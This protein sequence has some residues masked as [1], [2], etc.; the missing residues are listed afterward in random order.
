MARHRQRRKAKDA[1]GTGPS[2]EGSQSC[3]SSWIAHILWMAL[4]VATIGALIWNQYTL[5]F[6]S[7]TDEQIHFY[8]A[9]R[10]VEGAVLYR[11]ID[12]ARPPLVLLPLTWLLRLGVEPLLAGRALVLGTQLATAGLQLWGGRLLAS[13]R[14]GV[15]AALLFLTSPEVFSRIH[16]TGIHLVAL[17]T[18]AC[19][20]SFLRAQ[21]LL[22]GL[23]FGLTLA[24]D[25][26]GIV[27]CSVVALLTLFRRSRDIIPFTMGASLIA[28]IVF[29]GVWAM[30]GR[31]L[32]N[33][34]VDVHLHHFRLG[35]GFGAEF[36][37]K[38]R[39][40]L[41][42]HGYL[43]V[44][45]AL[46]FALLRTKREATKIEVPK[47]PSLSVVRVLL[48]VVGAHVAV[49][50]AMAESVFLYMVVIFPLLTLL[51]AIGY[52][53]ALAWW[54]QRHQ[55]P[56]AQARRASELMVAGAVVLVVLTAA[57]WGMSF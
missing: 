33:S 36:W 52:D 14:A 38:L 41:Y 24:A 34:L 42:E 32:W 8:I 15:I 44:G 2:K 7:W 12:S 4:I 43:F 39:P 49:V 26:H 56:H 1:G 35:D 6:Y 40:W 23:F 55:M 19:V 18:A 51:A 28:A 17:S 10:V 53:A 37:D 27:I 16:Y 5:Y 22:S 29:G 20:L 46:A 30:G 50:L 25:Q 11:D 57:G 31:N 47:L 48:I 9:R 45:A 13:K 54:R 21:P 3:S